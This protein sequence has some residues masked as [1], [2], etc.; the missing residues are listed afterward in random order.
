MEI[1]QDEAQPDRRYRVISVEKTDAPEGMFG[2]DW[3]RYVIGRG[4]SLIEGLRTGT[5]RSVTEHAESCVEVL[6]DRRVRGY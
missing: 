5:L 2:T 3:H 4:S 1:Y 6:N